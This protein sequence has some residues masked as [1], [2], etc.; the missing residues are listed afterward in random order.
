MAGRR[1][2]TRRVPA[3]AGARVS[4]GERRGLRRAVPR[5]G[6]GLAV[7]A[8]LHRLRADLAVVDDP[9]RVLRAVGG[10]QLQIAGRVPVAVHLFAQPYR[11]PAR[12]HRGG[13]DKRVCLDLG[14][15]AALAGRIELGESHALA[16]AQVVHANLAGL[17]ADR[18]PAV[19]VDGEAPTHV[20][21]LL[22]AADGLELANAAPEHTPPVGARVAGQEHDSELVLGDDLGP[23]RLRCRPAG[24]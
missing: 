9:L 19:G 5:V 20:R 1:L 15:I 16:T 4:A 2:A 18:R 7:G 24:R 23:A 13:A 6:E 17:V 11:R 21:G 22:L 14:G 8:D 3:Y 10:T 12:G